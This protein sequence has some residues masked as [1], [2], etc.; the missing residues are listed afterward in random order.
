[1]TLGNQILMFQERNVKCFY[2]NTPRLT[3]DQRVSICLEYPR[4][5]QCRINHMAEAAY[6]TGPA[7]LGAPRLL[8]SIF[9]PFFCSMFQ[10]ETQ[11]VRQCGALKS[12][13]PPE[14]A[15]APK[16]KK[17]GPI[18]LDPDVFFCSM[19]QCFS[20]GPQRAQGPQKTSGPKI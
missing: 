20:A 14:N 16:F 8:S 10:C 5:N 1:M 6:A 17:R 13:S 11:T 7:L 4:V 3:K 19:F 18:K 9:S 2:I 15:R 12:P